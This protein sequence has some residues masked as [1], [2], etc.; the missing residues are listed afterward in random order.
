MVPIIHKKGQWQPSTAGGFKRP[1]TVF[2]SLVQDH[3]VHISFPMVLSAVAVFI[4][5]K[6][7]WNLGDAEW[8][9]IL[10]W[11]SLFFYLVAFFA[12]WLNRS[13]ESVALHVMVGTLFLTIALNYLLSGN[14]LLSAYAVEAA[15]LHYLS[16]KT[17]ET[18]AAFAGA[19][20]FAM[21][22]LWYILRLFGPEVIPPILNEQAG[23][24]LA[25]LA[26]LVYAANQ[27]SD[28]QWSKVYALA[29]YLGFLALFLREFGYLPNGNG[30]ISITWGLTGSAALWMGL[31]RNR[32]EVFNA[33]LVTLVLVALKLLAIDFSFIDVIWRILIF[34]GF[35]AAFLLLSYW[36]KNQW[37]I[38][39]ANKST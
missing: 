33:G 34:L 13:H 7:V 22:S 8:G 9:A 30:L 24:D 39:S 19:V 31:R 11:A 10:L 28:E 5:S 36:I 35:G 12:W 23:A 1:E 15:A 16:G 27:V 37:K 38:L 18:A 21:L 26:M 25:L 2:E 20:L 3:N 17:R 6:A 14:K 4:M 32:L 29:A